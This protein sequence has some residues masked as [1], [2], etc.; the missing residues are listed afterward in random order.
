MYCRSA[1]VQIVLPARKPQRAIFP[2]C[3]EILNL[4][5]L[6]SVNCPPG[7]QENELAVGWSITF[8]GFA[9]IFGQWRSEG[10]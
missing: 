1:L 8:D 10:E 7:L 6:C 4:P 2:G 5:T 3:V 9:S